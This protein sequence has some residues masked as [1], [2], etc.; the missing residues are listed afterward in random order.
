MVNK[1]NKPKNKFFFHFSKS[2][3]RLKEREVAAI[4]TEVHKH[5]RDVFDVCQKS[6]IRFKQNFA[7]FVIWCLSPVKFEK[8]FIEKKKV[9]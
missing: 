7:V 5:E 4:L 6:Y 8:F 1:K 9:F 3:K 2:D